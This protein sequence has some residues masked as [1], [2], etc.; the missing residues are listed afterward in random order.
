MRGWKGWTA[1]GEAPMINVPSWDEWLTQLQRIWQAEYPV[2]HAVQ[3]S[4][5]EMARLRFLRW[6]H[7]TGRLDAQERDRI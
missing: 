3:F 4:E 6:L 5:Q 2:R 7:L 1:A